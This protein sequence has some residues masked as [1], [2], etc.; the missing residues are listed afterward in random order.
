MATNTE[1]RLPVLV[2]SVDQNS[3]SNCAQLLLR[4]GILRWSLCLRLIFEVALLTE[5]KKEHRAIKQ[6]CFAAARSMADLESLDE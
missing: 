2:R 3:E 4:A 6:P 1:A 5:H